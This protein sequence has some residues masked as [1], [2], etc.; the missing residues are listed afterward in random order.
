M[1]EVA[2]EELT[3]KMIAPGDGQRSARNIDNRLTLN[4][5]HDSNIYSLKGEGKTVH[6]R[7]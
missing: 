4:L 2:K 5:K 3:A 7:P 6:S 1:I